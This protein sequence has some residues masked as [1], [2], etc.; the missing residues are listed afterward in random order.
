MTW[1]LCL[2]RKK[3]SIYIFEI[4]IYCT[5]LE[6]KYWKH[7]YNMLTHYTEC[8]RVVSWACAFPCLI[9]ALP[10][11]RWIT[12]T[13]TPQTVLPHL[14]TTQWK[15][16]WQPKMAGW[17]LSVDPERPQSPPS[18]GAKTLSCFP[19]LPG[20]QSLSVCLESVNILYICI[21]SQRLV[22]QSLPLLFLILGI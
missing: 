10:C 17:W 19:T 8:F 4:S 3:K 13:V 5:Y 21:H 22:Y 2:A 6:N 9:C 16:C 15:E 7:L 18:P 1:G 14:N 12:D 20:E 11:L